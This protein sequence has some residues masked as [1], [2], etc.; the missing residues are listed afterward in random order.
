MNEAIEARKELLEVQA[1]DS[2]STDACWDS[3]LPVCGNSAGDYLVID[4]ANAGDSPIAHF[5]HETGKFLKVESS[6][7]RL[8][9]RTAIEIDKGQLIYD[10][11]SN[12][13]R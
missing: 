2:P 13:M 8:L 12:S 3:R 1:I 11:E 6:F 5:S 9:Q 7:L 4:L 10:Q